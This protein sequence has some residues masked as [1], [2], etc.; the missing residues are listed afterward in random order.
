[1]RKGETKRTG[2]LRQAGTVR[3]RTSAQAM[4]DASVAGVVDLKLEEQEMSCDENV[5]S[6]E[7]NYNGMPGVNNGAVCRD[8]HEGCEHAVEAE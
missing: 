6:D 7:A 8:A 1:M 2:R 4:H 3:G 5:G